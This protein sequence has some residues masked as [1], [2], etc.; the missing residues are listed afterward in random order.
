MHQSTSVNCA[1]VPVVQRCRL[2]V[3][4]SDKAYVTDA[5]RSTLFLG[6][7]RMA[8]RGLSTPRAALCLHACLCPKLF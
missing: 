1:V 7:A 8:C 6:A 3:S 5:C 4:V 2:A